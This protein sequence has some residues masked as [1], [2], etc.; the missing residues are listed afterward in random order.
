MT[1]EKLL[2]WNVKKVYFLYN[3]TFRT[4]I[5]GIMIQLQSCLSLQVFLMRTD[6]LNKIISLPNFRNQFF[7][8][9]C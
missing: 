6:Y 9:I 4:H 8:G 7:P 2:N 3:Q 5:S 1:S